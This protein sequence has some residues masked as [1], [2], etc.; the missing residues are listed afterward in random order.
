MFVASQSAVIGDLARLHCQ[1]F[2][3]RA[4]APGITISAEVFAWVKAETSDVAECADLPPLVSRAMRL[5]A[6]FDHP[7]FVFARDGHDLVHLSGQSIEM[8][9]DDGLGA[10]RDLRLNLR[11]INC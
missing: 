9:R 6:I 5:G 11:R 2:V 7:Q 4:E 3:I 10:A 8:H 1:R